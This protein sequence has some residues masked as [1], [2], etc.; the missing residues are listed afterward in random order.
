MP[1]SQSL[2]VRLCLSDGCV[3]LAGGGP[4]NPSTSTLGRAHLE[5][6]VKK[7][8]LVSREACLV[9]AAAGTGPATVAALAR[10]KAPVVLE[11]RA[12][13][14]ATA[15]QRL[16]LRP[17]DAPRALE[18][19]DVI[20]LCPGDEEDDEEEARRQRVVVEVEGA[21]EEEEEEEEKDPPP[22][23]PPPQKEPQKKQQ[24]PSS[25]PL[26]MLVLVGLP[27]SGK[28]CLAEALIA[29]ANAAVREFDDNDRQET[30]AAA[31]VAA[32][33][34]S[35]SGTKRHKR[36]QR[37]REW[38]RVSQD[39][40][41]GSEAACLAAAAQG[42]ASGFSVVAD[43]TN[44]TAKQRSPFLALA[45]KHKAEAHALY[46]KRP[47][48]KC[49][50]RAY[51]RPSHEAGV[52]SRTAVGAVLGMANIDVEAPS[53]SPPESFARVRVLLDDAANDSAAEEYASWRVMMSGEGEG[54]GGGGAAAAAAKRT[55]SAFDVLMAPPAAKR[56]PVIS[57][58]APDP[59]ASSASRIPLP[60]FLNALRLI[61]E[62]PERAGTGAVTRVAGASTGTPLL[63]LRD[64]F[65]KARSHALVMQETAANFRLI[66]S[67][68]DLRPEDASLMR[69]L[70]VAGR[71][72][73]ASE[74]RQQQQQQQQKGGGAKDSKE[75]RFG[76]HS[77]PSLEPMHLHAVSQDLD[78]L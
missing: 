69:D 73:A 60:P 74:Q 14:S 53:T 66:A 23:S 19:K 11:R 49:M 30:G 40:L 71:R 51:E 47:K 78:L 29:H 48:R 2:L 57:S 34:A 37:P 17:G 45:K 33:A 12:S 54:G 55:R 31:A 59:A 75:F 8:R 42:L 77:S 21:E 7:R 27:G 46:L 5:K 15:F 32:A 9:S 65:P 22:P 64:K 52:R 3:L 72:W 24:Q 43:R 20:Q 67:P 62:N 16:T 39:A 6:G 25:T 68:R 26:I 35:S 13:A 63:V 41:R 44:L 38:V 10:S 58:P 76:F 50:E 70:L 1:P 61:S 36:R 4:A 18:D 56:A 28:S